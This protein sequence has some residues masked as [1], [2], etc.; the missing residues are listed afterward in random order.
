[1]TRIHIY[2]LICPICMSVFNYSDYWKEMRINRRVHEECL[3]RLNN[4]ILAFL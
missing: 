4:T 2:Y 1:M 3:L